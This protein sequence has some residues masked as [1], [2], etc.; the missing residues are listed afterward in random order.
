LAGEYWLVVEYSPA[1]DAI[2]YYTYYDEAEAREH[3]VRLGKSEYFWY[4]W[5]GMYGWASQGVDIYPK[6]R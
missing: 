4:W 2:Y 5:S 3:A 6:P 1:K